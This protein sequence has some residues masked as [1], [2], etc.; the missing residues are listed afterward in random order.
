[1]LIIS[2]TKLDINNTN[3][4]TFLNFFFIVSGCKQIG[5]GGLEQ[6]DWSRRF[7]AGGLEQAD[8][9]RKIKEGGSSL[10]ENVITECSPI[11]YGI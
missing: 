2:N 1:M 11:D 6:V 9:S 5:T 4:Q 7:G 3:F 10:G 8:W